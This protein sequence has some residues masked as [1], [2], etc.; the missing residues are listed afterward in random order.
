M[1]NLNVDI[2]LLN[3]SIIKNYEFTNYEKC[4]HIQKDPRLRFSRKKNVS[5]SKIFWLVNKIM[6]LVLG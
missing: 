1:N 2:E 5:S 3:I 6:S 4:G